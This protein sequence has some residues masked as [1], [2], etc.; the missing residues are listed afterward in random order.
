MGPNSF[1]FGIGLLFA[2]AKAGFLYPFLNETG[3]KKGE[4]H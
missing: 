3:R 1:R 2:W 4:Q